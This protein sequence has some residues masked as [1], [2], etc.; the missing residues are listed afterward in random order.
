MK[1][2]RERKG[3]EVV[4]DQ[5]PRKRLRSYRFRTYRQRQI[6]RAIFLACAVVLVVSVWNLGSYVN[7]YNR[8]RRQ[9]AEL[10]ALYA[11][12]S[13]AP[14]AYVTHPPATQPIQETVTEAPLDERPEIET[15]A[16]TRDPLSTM[17]PQPYPA[18]PY[19]LIGERFSKLRRQNSDIVGWLD[20]GEILQQAVVQRDNSYYLRRDYQ[21]YH[22]QNGAIFLDEACGLQTRPHTLI[23][24]GHNMKTGAMFGSLRNYENI[25]FYHKNP[26][27]T[28][29]TIYEEGRYVIFSVAVVSTNSQSRKYAGFYRLP[30]CTILERETIIQ[31]LRTQ[32]KH[33]C[34][35]DVNADDQLLLLVTC[36]DDD[37]D[38][39][40]VAARRIRD[41]ES[42]DELY[43]QV[44]RSW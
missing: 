32:S 26:F 5:R 1:I 22:N 13:D 18:N 16:P 12:V 36:V 4:H 23:L 44:R 14:T 21:G 11:E 25:T 20:M 17:V 27:I 7:D 19:R 6:E 24:Y 3:A 38:R 31:G 8:S 28:F 40:I 39:R 2:S 10:L 41:D 35:I 43:R 42:E 9:A 30:T 34:T 33:T 29:D 37:A 15:I